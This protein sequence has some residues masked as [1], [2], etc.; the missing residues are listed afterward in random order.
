LDSLEGFAFN[1]PVFFTGFAFA[2]ALAFGAAAGLAG[3]TS[4]FAT[5]SGT[6]SSAGFPTRFLP[7]LADAGVAGEALLVDATGST[8]FGVAAYNENHS[9]SVSSLSCVTTFSP[10]SLPPSS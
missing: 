4:T 5:F 2:T 7:P 6:S 1:S 10:V 8:A 3:V 9:G